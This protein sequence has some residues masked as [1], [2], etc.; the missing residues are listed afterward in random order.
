MKVHVCTPYSIEKNLG[1]AYNE[2]MAVIPKGDWACLIDHDVVFLLPDQIKHLH[3]YVG[4]FPDT[5]IFTCLTNRLHPAANDQ[6]LGG[7]VTNN[8]NI[9]HHINR[10]EKQKR[11]LYQVTEINHHI[12][13]FLMMISKSTWNNIKFT[14][15]KKCLGVDNEFS[16]AVLDSGRNIL[17]MDG[18]YVFH[19]YRIMKGIKD[20]SHLV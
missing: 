12:S 18:I 6:L 2:A 9:D 3:D 15:D 8:P 16:D 17:R 7:Q 5:G 4:L 1:K 13:G 14:E 11:H 20:K 19:Q 10:A